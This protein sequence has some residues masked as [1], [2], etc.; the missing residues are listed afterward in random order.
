M[1]ATTSHELRT[2]LNSIIHMLALIEEN[3]KDETELQ[4]VKVAKSSS[5]LMLYLV[6]DTLDYH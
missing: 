1:I 5:M 6:N 2:P 4:W 3:A